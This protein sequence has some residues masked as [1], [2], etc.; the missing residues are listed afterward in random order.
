M[1]VR[2]MIFADRDDLPNGMVLESLEGNLQIWNDRGQSCG[3][4]ERRGSRWLWS[5]SGTTG[6]A[7]DI[8]IAWLAVTQALAAA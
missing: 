1:I 5:A 2:P 3:R 4:C 8:G 7:P 6:I